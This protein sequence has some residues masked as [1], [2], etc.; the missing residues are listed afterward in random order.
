M[1]NTTKIALGVGLLGMVLLLRAKGSAIVDAISKAIPD[2]GIYKLAGAGSGS[3]V[4][5]EHKGKVIAKKD[6]FVYCSGF[7]FAVVM[8]AAKRKGLLKNKSV[9]DVQRFQREWYGS[10]GDKEKQQG[11]A[12]EK[13]GVGRSIPMSAA[14]PGDFAQFWRTNGTGHSVV[15]KG[16]IK[17]AKGE[18]VGLKYRSA[19]NATGVADN[20]EKFVG[21]GGN[22]NPARTYF[23]R[24]G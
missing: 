12:L 3:P 4:E 19:Q 23:S 14:Q 16:W 18:I 21:K 24:L 13:L 22:V 7:T 9:E 1:K 5:I 15:F 17:D 20:S 8:E 11:P 6:D 2:G 10:A